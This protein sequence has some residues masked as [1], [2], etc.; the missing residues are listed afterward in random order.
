METERNIFL[1]INFDLK[2]ETI[3]SFLNENQKTSFG[4]AKTSI[5]LVIH[6]KVVIKLSSLP[7]RD[8]IKKIELIS[9]SDY[10]K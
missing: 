3:K 8:G 4:Y 9:Y 10:N 5:K 1:F 2:P 7:V 6:L